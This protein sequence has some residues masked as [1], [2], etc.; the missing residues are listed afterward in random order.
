MP[1]PILQPHGDPTITDLLRYYG[2]AEL[3]WTRHVAEETTLDAGVAFTNPELPRVFE[4]NRMFDV[5]LPDGTTPQQAFDEAEQHFATAG[6]RCWSW[7]MNPAAE[8]S[9]TDAMAAFLLARGY[10]RRAND[11]MILKGF[12]TEPLR[13]VAN[14]TIIPARA[15]FRHSRTIAEEIAADWKAPELADAFMLHLDDPHTDSLLAL[16]GGVAAAFLA[17]LAAG[18]TGI[19][20]HL[21]V[22]AAF[23]GQGMGRTMMSRALEICARSLFKHF[24]I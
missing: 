19:I 8:P 14:L 11:V 20:A 7:N 1:L 17:V 24:F 9:R 2:R 5:A 10:A 16:R 6:T 15:S 21:H 4:A 3:H 18:E 22:A 23:R 12:P 13:E